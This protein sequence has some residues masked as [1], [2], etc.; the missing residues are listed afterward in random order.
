MDLIQPRGRI[1]SEQVRNS[2]SHSHRQPA[3]PWTLCRGIASTAWKKAPPPLYRCNACRSQE[4]IVQTLRPLGPCRRRL[5][6]R[7][8]VPLPKLCGPKGREVAPL[9]PAQWQP[10]GRCLS[11]PAM[12]SRELPCVARPAAILDPTNPLPPRIWTVGIPRHSRIG[13]G[14]RIPGY[15]F[16][17]RRLSSNSALSISP[18][19][20]RSL[21]ISSAVL[22]VG[23]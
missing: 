15:S 2:R 19:A 18:R 10:T 5:G 21:R 12:I 13:A 16:R 6:R 4:R 17:A 22:P 3:V 1:E 9:H 23:T 8:Q 14:A 11:R 20:K 7:R